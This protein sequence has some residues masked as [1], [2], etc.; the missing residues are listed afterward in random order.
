M[1]NHQFITVINFCRRDVINRIKRTSGCGSTVACR[2][3]TNNSDSGTSISTA[4]IPDGRCTS[5]GSGLP[6]PSRLAYFKHDTGHVNMAF[7]DLDG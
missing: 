6:P 7:L 5:K 4:N 3:L 1:L 2:K